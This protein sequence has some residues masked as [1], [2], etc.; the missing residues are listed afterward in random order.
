MIIAR[1]RAVFDVPLFNFDKRDIIWNSRATCVYKINN[2]NYIGT[3]NGLYVIK[4]DYGH[5]SIN[6]GSLFPILMD[7]IIAITKMSVEDLWIA[8]ENNGL[9]CIRADKVIYQLTTQNGLTSNECRCLYASKSTL[10]LGTDKGIS[11]IDLS[12]YPFQIVNFT[13][14][15]GLDCEIV[16]CIYTK[17]DSVFAGT[18]FGLTFFKDIKIQ[19]KSICQLKLLDIKSN[20]S[21][22]YYCQDSIIFQIVIIFYDL[23]M[24]VFLLVWG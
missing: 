11:K 14:A 4:N 22:W 10:W 24:P 21:D 9:V 13:A 20:K 15:D 7:K 23:N 17:G 19:K 2:R 6:L 16:N 18:P 8:T 3:L 5:S 12:H 1:D